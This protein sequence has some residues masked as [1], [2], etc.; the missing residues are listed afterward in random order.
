MV[1]A[2]DSV[3]FNARNQSNR[4]HRHCRRELGN[5]HSTQS[6]HRHLATMFMHFS[7]NI[8]IIFSQIHW[9]MFLFRSFLLFRLLP[10]EIREGL[11]I[12]TLE[13]NSQT[14]KWIFHAA[15]R[16]VEMEN[17]FQIEFFRVVCDVIFFSWKIV[18]FSRT[19]LKNISVLW[20]HLRSQRSVLLWKRKL[21]MFK[22]FYFGRELRST[23]SRVSTFP[24]KIN[25]FGCPTA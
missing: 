23:T 12:S 8:R 21:A 9:E 14:A 4:K 10:G 1:F 19:A 18:L 16:E 15:N 2:G 22:F 17:Y 11:Y 20:K 3:K 5:K 13:S 7:L 25:I 24:K 6:L